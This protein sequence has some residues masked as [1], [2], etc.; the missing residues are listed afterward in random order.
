MCP[1]TSLDTSSRSLETRLQD[2]LQALLQGSLH[3]LLEERFKLEV[4]L[5]ERTKTHLEERSPIPVFA[6]V[7]W[8]FERLQTLNQSSSLFS[9]ADSNLSLRTSHGRRKHA[10]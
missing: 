4:R 2:L 6:R 1:D 3:T 9:R 10:I 7:C 8:V 5:E